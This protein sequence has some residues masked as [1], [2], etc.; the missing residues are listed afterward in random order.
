MQIL[1]KRLG[2]IPPITYEIDPNATMD[3]LM[4]QIKIMERGD[5]PLTWY[6]F[7]EESTPTIHLV[8]RIGGWGS[9]LI[10][11]TWDRKSF[12][13]YGVGREKTVRHLKGM[14]CEKTG[15][16]PERQHLTFK[17]KE[18]GDEQ[19]LAELG[20]RSYEVF[21]LSRVEDWP[22]D[23]GDSWIRSLIPHTTFLDGV[24]QKQFPKHAAL[25]SRFPLR[26]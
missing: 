24:L 10:T 14:I 15:L 3:N 12:P 9:A 22:R 17:G 6:G 21:R 26:S 19:T 2:D 11:Q 20:V 13:A 25:L 4:T 1:V 18:V 8:L 16:R 23:F 5:T 7:T